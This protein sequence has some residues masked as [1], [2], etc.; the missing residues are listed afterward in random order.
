M[1][2][3][4]VAHHENTNKYEEN[5]YTHL[6][7]DL[8]E[9]NV[10]RQSG[11]VGNVMPSFQVEGFV[12]A[13]ACLTRLSCYTYV[14]PLTLSFL[15]TLFF[16]FLRIPYIA[17]IYLECT[18]ILRS[19]HDHWTCMLWQCWPSQGISINMLEIDTLTYICVHFCPMLVKTSQW[20]SIQHV[21]NWCI[22]SSLCQFLPKV[23]Q[24]KSVYLYQT[25]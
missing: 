8:L 1:H 23:S 16:T 12:W 4:L 2:Y 15:L 18:L 13:S 9:K 5:M 25:C 17:G 6:H 7:K 3:V 21:W 10:C 14:S 19:Q 20:F 11:H 24:Y 22:N